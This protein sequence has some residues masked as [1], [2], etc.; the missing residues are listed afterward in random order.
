MHLEL[1]FSIS[2][3]RLKTQIVKMRKEHEMPIILDS[4]IN[5]DA[6]YSKTFHI[7][8]IRI[9]VS[10]TRLKLCNADRAN[11]MPDAKSLKTLTNVIWIAKISTRLLNHVGWPS[12]RRDFVGNRNA[13]ALAWAPALSRNSL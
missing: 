7:F 12:R 13:N 3:A 4:Q 10:G 9:A 2:G 5:A 1:Q 11:A 6:H 8:R